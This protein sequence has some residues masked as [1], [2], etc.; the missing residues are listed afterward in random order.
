MNSNP[1]TFADYAEVCRW[2][3]AHQWPC[4]PLKMLPTIGVIIKTTQGVGVCAGW[5]Y[6]TDSCMTVLEWVISNPEV[7]SQTRAEGLDLLISCIIE[8]AKRLGPDMQ[9]FT[10]AQHPK[11]IERYKTHGFIECDRGMTNFIRHVWQ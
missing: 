2:W 8:H 6:R 7:S 9:I 4:L 3:K 1:F 5:L 11:L 10:S